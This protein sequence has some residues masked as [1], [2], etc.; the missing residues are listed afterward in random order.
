[1]YKYVNKKNI[2]TT[3][4]GISFT[5]YSGHTSLTPVVAL[6][7]AS[8]GWDF[9][10]YYNEVLANTSNDD[11]PIGEIRYFP[12][13]PGN[14]WL[15]C[16]GA[17]YLRTDYPQYEGMRPKSAILVSILSAWMNQDYVQCCWTGQSYLAAS[18]WV[19]RTLYR[20]LDGVVWAPMVDVLPLGMGIARTFIARCGAGKL[21]ALDMVAGKSSISFD[22]GTTWSAP[23]TL[24]TET[25]PTVESFPR[26]TVPVITNTG[27]IVSFKGGTNMVAKS[28]DGTSWDAFPLPASGAWMCAFDAWSSNSDV[29]ALDGSSSGKVAEI[30][31]STLVY[32]TW[33]ACSAYYGQQ[34]GSCQA[35]AGEFQVFLSS[36]T[37]VYSIVK[38]GW[39]DL[40][41]VSYD[42]PISPPLL[43]AC[44][45]IDARVVSAS[46]RHLLVIDPV[47]GE[48][49]IF[50]AIPTATYGWYASAASNPI[51][52]TSLFIGNGSV[53]QLSVNPLKFNAPG[54]A[55]KAN[56]H[57]YVYTG[58]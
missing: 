40:H 35:T 3:I 20:S 2:S 16:D 1:M 56:T 51:N 37:Q 13:N 23:A 44:S 31:G 5:P 34:N 50:N 39:Y 21:L 42:L 57:P 27:A 12:S 32:Q 4:G 11:T 41:E 43:G 7:V 46:G 25:L 10:R 45:A 26:W 30:Y 53:H 54:L 14:G 49:C 17:P 38:D 52:N 48:E 6:D 15:K 18:G 36:N 47:G 8:N 29:Y 33:F 28:A 22:D 55:S 19:S 24:P 58:A 9:D